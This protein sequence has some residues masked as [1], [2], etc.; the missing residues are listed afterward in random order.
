MH[1]ELAV[2]RDIDLTR[3]LLA[4][5]MDPR[6]GKTPPPAPR[7]PT[8]GSKG[9]LL[10]LASMFS[11]LETFTLL[12]SHGANLS[13][14]HALHGAACGGPSQ[15]P[16]IRHLLDSKA[17][18]VDELDVYHVPHTGTPLLAAITQ[19]HVEVVRVLLGYGAHPLAC[20]K[21]PYETSA[22]ESARALGRRDEGASKEI[23]SM[24]EEARGEREGEGRLG[25]VPVSGGRRSGTS[26]T[27]GTPGT[28]GETDS[29]PP[30]PTTHTATIPST[31]LWLS[32]SVGHTE[33]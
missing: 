12:H 4:Q 30:T 28:P 21:S 1:S 11:S 8:R 15:I 9:W 20:I 2:L 13:Y 33:I 6:V 32:C 26:G 14:A 25:G 19:G 27:S 18:D 16:I 24:L 31:S 29:G 3:F 22:E 5:G 10:Y 7:T 23:L 17:V